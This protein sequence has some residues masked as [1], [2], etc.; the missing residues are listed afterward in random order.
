MNPELEAEAAAFDRR[1]EERIRAGFVPDLRRATKCTYFYKSFWRD[2]HF[3]KLYEVE[4]VNTLLEMLRRHS[5]GNLRVLDVGCGAGYVSLEFARA[6]H[7]VLGIDISHKCIEIAREYRDQN[8]FTEG[9]GSLDYEVMTLEEVTEPFDCVLFSGCLHHF[10]DP[11]KAVREAME[12]LPAGGLILAYEPCHEQ[13]RMQDA[14][15]VAL[16]RGLLALTGFWYEEPFELK[17]GGSEFPTLVQD[18]HTE[19][20]T[21]RDKDEVGGQSPN[22]NSASGEVIL[23]AL[24]EHLRELEYKPGFSFIYRLLGGLRGPDETVYGI[25]DFLAAY[26]KYSIAN[27][28]LQPN[29]FFFLG[30]KIPSR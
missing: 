8:P 3:I 30:K 11:A 17:D 9:F 13:W 29:Y 26:E 7:R 2:P 15:Q 12:L 1:I 4:G 28:F 21:E 23:N 24:R 10:S 27:E 5:G 19:Y 20:V 14:A 25:A 18:V 16:I 6:G 22:D